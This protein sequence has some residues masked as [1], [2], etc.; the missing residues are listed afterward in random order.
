MSDFVLGTEPLLDRLDRPTDLVD[1]RPGLHQQ[2]LPILYDELAVEAPEPRD[3]RVHVVDQA[4]LEHRVCKQRE[5]IKV[6]FSKAMGPMAIVQSVLS[7]G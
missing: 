1:P 2:Q 5:V 6:S 3:G 4:H 7:F